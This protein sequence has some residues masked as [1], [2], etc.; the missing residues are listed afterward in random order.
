[1]SPIN[2]VLSED[3]GGSVVVNPSESP[4]SALQRYFLVDLEF[5]TLPSTRVA[6]GLPAKPPAGENIAVSSRILEAMKSSDDLPK[7][8][9]T[10]AWVSAKLVDSGTCKLSGFRDIGGWWRSA[11]HKPSPVYYT[12]CGGGS[13]NDRIYVNAVTGEIFR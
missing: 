7:Y 5:D 4:P 3:G 9:N 8:R 11:A 1:M 10:F 2:P 13:N 12:Y 6:E